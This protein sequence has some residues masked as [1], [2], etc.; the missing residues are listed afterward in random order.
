MMIKDNKFTFA[1]KLVIYAPSLVLL[2]INYPSALI[3]L[4]LA[5]LLIL[6]VQWKLKH[7]KAEDK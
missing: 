6:S 2:F 4:I 3:Y 7:A 5:N 1:G